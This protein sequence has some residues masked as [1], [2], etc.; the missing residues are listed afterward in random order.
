MQDQRRPIEYVIQHIFYC[1][2]LGQ[3]SCGGDS[4]GPLLYGSGIGYGEPWIQIGV[5]SFGPDKC[6]EKY[7]GNVVPGTYTYLPAFMNWIVNSIKP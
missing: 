5:V 7:E 6:G 2:L 4:G 3:D 1:Y